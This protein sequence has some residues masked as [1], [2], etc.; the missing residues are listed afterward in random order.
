VCVI[1]TKMGTAAGVATMMLVTTSS[2]IIFQL[3]LARATPARSELIISSPH[4]TEETDCLQ[5]RLQ[6]EKRTGCP[7]QSAF[8]AGGI[9]PAVVSQIG[10]Q[11]NLPARVELN[12]L[13]FRR[14][15]ELELLPSVRDRPGVGSHAL[16]CI[17]LNAVLDNAA[18]HRARRY[19]NQGAV[20]KQ[21]EKLDREPRF[22]QPADVD[23]CVVGGTLF[24]L[25][26]FFFDLNSLA[27][28]IVHSRFR[29]RGRGLCFGDLVIECRRAPDELIEEP[30]EVLAAHLVR[31]IE[32]VLGSW[33]AEA[34]PLM[35]CAH[36]LSHHVRAEKALQRVERKACA[37]IGIDAIAERIL[38]LPRECQNRVVELSL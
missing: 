13:Y 31:E 33:M 18:S 7:A 30:V 12:H 34:P 21:D 27:L 25:L 37:R 5:G 10:I 14:S 8:G 16:V 9:A 26:V 22:A 1:T 20:L 4:S 3:R 11:Q 28:T 6:P 19:P 29:V 32:E 15:S 35:I 17:V 23:L 24:G 36:K 38:E 2:R